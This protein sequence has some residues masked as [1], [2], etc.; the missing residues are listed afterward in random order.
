MK[1][2][3]VW[4]FER[5][6]RHPGW[7]CR[8]CNKWVYYHDSREC[9]CELQ[10]TEGLVICEFASGCSNISCKHYA[11]HKHIHCDGDLCDETSTR[12]SVTKETQ[13][14]VKV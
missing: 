7:R 9:E 10:P 8:G 12:C 6:S 4:V 14:C 1:T 3:S 2:Q 5:L 13:I 11:P